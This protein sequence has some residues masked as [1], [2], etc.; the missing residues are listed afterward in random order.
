M[1]SIIDLS[2]AET[3]GVFGEGIAN[4]RGRP[5]TDL[6]VASSTAGNQL[7][8]LRCTGQSFYSLLQTAS[9]IVCGP[10]N[11]FH[12]HRQPAFTPF[13]DELGPPQPT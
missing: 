2:L 7:D 3:E 9:E 8:S 1:T 4:S 6:A 5:S 12:S 11:G 13:P 10:T